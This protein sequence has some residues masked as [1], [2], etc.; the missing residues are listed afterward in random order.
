MSCPPTPGGSRFARLPLG[1]APT[2][3]IAQRD[4]KVHLGDLATP[5]GL[6][7]GVLDALPAILTAKDL[8]ALV[9][10]LGSRWAQ[11]APVLF[12]LGGHVV[13][14]GLGP[15]V[16]RLLEEDK[17]TAVAMNGGAAIHDL[18]LAFFGKT[19]E[20]VE[21]TL[22]LG[23]FGMVQETGEL[24]AEALR[25][26]PGVGLGESLGR[27]IAASAPHSDVSVLGAA[28]RTG[29]PATVHLGLG[30][31]TVHYHP[32]VELSR[33]SEAAIVD[34]EV[35]GASILESL[36]GGAYINCGSAVLLP[37]IFLK[38]LNLARATRGDQ[39]DLVTADFDM[40]P[41][42]RAM[43]NVVL[44]PTAGHPRG[45]SFVGQHEVL[46][47]IFLQLLL[48]LDQTADLGP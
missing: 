7:I 5:M 26:S 18:E 43:T 39:G 16:A 32:S 25:H 9:E 42:Y 33:L 29:H 11:R 20:Y 6:P 10:G 46:L 37:E 19:S 45:Y 8:R 34:L 36:G 48:G 40:H 44:R 38:L 22:S 24:M 15:L 12:G 2:Y 28:W 30:A 47:C 17:I 27:L 3:S 23:Q 35:F 14:C 1:S 4:H 41:A 13:K 21:V 31:D